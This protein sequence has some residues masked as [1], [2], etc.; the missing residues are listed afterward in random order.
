MNSSLVPSPLPPLG[1]G[2][3]WICGYINRNGCSKLSICVASDYPLTPVDPVT[4]ETGLP[5]PTSSTSDVQ[6]LECL[7]R[8][9]VMM[10]QLTGRGGS[11]HQQ[12]CLAALGYC[13]A[14]WKVW[15]GWGETKGT[16][17]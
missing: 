9:H 13:I 12:L 3:A 8:V 16:G 14:V 4:S 17:S 11:D 10:A 5:T 7:M 1:V 6:L 15:P 2:G